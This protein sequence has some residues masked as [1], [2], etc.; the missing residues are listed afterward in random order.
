M[1]ARIAVVFFIAGAALALFWLLGP[2]DGSA[3]DGGQGGADVPATAAGGP[4]SL[5]DSGTPRGDRRWS[6]AAGGAPTRAGEGEAE[7]GG[8]PAGESGE[9]E[10]SAAADDDDSA[11]VSRPYPTDYAGIKAAMEG[12]ID[13]IKECYDAWVTKNPEIE[14]KIVLG[15]DIEPD[16]EAPAEAGVRSVQ[17]L[18]GSTVD[19]VFLEGCVVSA[20]EEMRFEAP[21]DGG[22]LTVNYPFL[23]RS[24]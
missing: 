18:D 8:R 1:N 15:F 21:A 3:P 24:E 12:R 4:P 22:S 23:F 16:E 19:H 6:P 7:A 5:G 2:E 14:G 20:V 11:G 10:G 13:D 9:V 17:I